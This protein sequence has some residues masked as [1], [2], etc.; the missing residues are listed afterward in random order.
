LLIELQEELRASLEAQWMP[1][2]WPWNL[3]VS[4][5]EDYFGEEISE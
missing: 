1:F 4:K 2:D 5:I 3:P